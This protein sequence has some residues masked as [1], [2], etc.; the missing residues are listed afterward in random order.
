LHFHIENGNSPLGAEGL[1]YSLSSFEVV[2]RGEGWKPADA[3]GPA[4]VHRNEIP[5]ENEAVNFTPYF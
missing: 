3:M 1:P 2:G 4:E 5:L